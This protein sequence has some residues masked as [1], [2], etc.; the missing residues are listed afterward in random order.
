MTGR[1]GVTRKRV[2]G[3]EGVEGTEELGNGTDRDREGTIS[4]VNMLTQSVEARTLFMLGQIVCTHATKGVEIARDMST[5]GTDHI[6]VA[7]DDEVVG[8][9]SA[10]G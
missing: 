9:H 3:G 4:T 8:G 7:I 1:Y 10:G 5:F 2:G 6:R